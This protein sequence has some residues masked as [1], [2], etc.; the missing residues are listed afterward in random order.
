MVHRIRSRRLLVSAALG[1]LAPWLWAAPGAALSFGDDFGGGSLD[2]FYWAVESSNLS[3]VDASSGRVVVTQM[4]GAGVTRITFR[5]PMAG[6]YTVTVG[7]ELVDWPADNKERLGL[8]ELSIGAAERTSDSSFGGEVYLSDLRGLPAGTV[9]P[10]VA[11]TDTSGTLRF[12]RIGGEVCASFQGGASFADLQCL[13]DPGGPDG[14]FALQVWRDGSGGDGIQV[15]LDG[16]AIEAPDAHICGDGAEDGPE[17]CDDG[18]TAAGDGCDASCLDE[19]LSTCPAA[20]STQCVAAGKASLSIQEKNAGKERLTAKLQGFASATAQ[21]DF[22]D[23]VTGSTRYDL[24]VYGPTGALVASLGVDRAGDA[25]GPQARPCWKDKRGK[26]WSYKDAGGSASGVRKLSASS[27]PA[28]KGKLQL[29]AGNNAAKG[30]SA[31]PAGV[32]AALEGASSATLQLLAS[33]GPCYE[34]AL[35]T[36]QKADGVQ[37]KAKAP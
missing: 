1:G 13:N 7:Y 3:S 4:G 37:F 21:A 9:T 11:T 17:E 22:G 6:D 33:D 8:L 14:T 29:Q 23:P 30:Q 5:H 32:V 10:G 35:A 2:P 28:G 34:A 24:C 16:F 26:G 36:V 27:G 20:P 31:L 15:A 19:T 18:N 12:Q 25:C